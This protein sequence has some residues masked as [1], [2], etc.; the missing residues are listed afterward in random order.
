MAR[1]LAMWIP[2]ITGSVKPSGQVRK[3]IP[4][5]SPSLSSMLDHQKQP[6]PSMTP[7]L[8]RKPGPKSIGWRSSTVQ[9]PGSKTAKPRSVASS[10]PPEAMG[11][12]ALARMGSSVEPATPRSGSY[13]ERRRPLMSNQ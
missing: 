2:E 11:A 6:S 10:R 1:L 5:R 4:G 7:S 9:V 13:Q 8:L 12:A 3:I